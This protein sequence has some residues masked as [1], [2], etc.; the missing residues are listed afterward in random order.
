[1]LYVGGGVPA[2]SYVPDAGGP[3]LVP[4][5]FQRSDEG[6]HADNEYLRIDSFKKGQRAYAQLLH[7]LVGQPT[8]D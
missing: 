3:S 1:V 2:L 6:F 4:F 7:A 8:R 5:S